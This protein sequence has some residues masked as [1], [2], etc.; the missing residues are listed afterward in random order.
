MNGAFFKFA[1]CLSAI[2]SLGHSGTVNAVPCPTAASINN[3]VGRGVL[4]SD[5]PTGRVFFLT[6]RH[7]VT[8]HGLFHHEIDLNFKCLNGQSVHRQIKDGEK[9]WLTAAKPELDF[10]WIELREDELPPQGNFVTANANAFSWNSIFLSMGKDVLVASYND[11]A[12]TFTKDLTAE[13][14]KFPGN[15]N[16]TCTTQKI[17]C[18]NVKI[19]QSES[20]SPVFVRARSGEFTD[21]IGIVTVSADDCDEGGFMP[22]AMIADKLL[23]S[24][25]GLFPTRLCDHKKLW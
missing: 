2:A 14:I 18:L 10:S 15:I 12:A 5:S 16:L 22:V 4:V 1:V 24:F 21:L 25:R 11:R 19:T 8:Y 6:A 7:V 17:G 20:G 3:G 23:S 9:R 13:G